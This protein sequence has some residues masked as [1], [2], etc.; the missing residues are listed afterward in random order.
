MQECLSW[1]VLPQRLHGAADKILTRV[2]ISSEG[3]GGAGGSTCRVT[4]V[5]VGRRPQFLA[6]WAS[7]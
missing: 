4:H 6:L 2:V 5:A 3:P 1:V 7:L